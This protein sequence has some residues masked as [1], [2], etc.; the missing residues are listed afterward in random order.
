MLLSPNSLPRFKRLYIIHFFLPL[1]STCSLPQFCFSIILGPLSISCFFSSVPLHMLF[2][3]PRHSLWSF[4]FTCLIPDSC[5]RCRLQHNLPW[6]PFP[7]DGKRCALPVRFH[8]TVYFF[9][10]RIYHNICKYSYLPLLCTLPMTVRVFI[11]SSGIS[12]ESSRVN[13]QMFIE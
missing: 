8:N 13:T 9:H 4:K 3:L 1:Q 2:S 11:L 7:T 6:E 10:H 5:F 12:L